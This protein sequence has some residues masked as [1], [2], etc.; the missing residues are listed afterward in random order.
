MTLLV[1][2]PALPVRD[3]PR[4]VAFYRDRLGFASRHVDDGMGIVVRD[5]VEI[6]L[7]RANSPTTPGAE[8]Y[9]AGSASCRIRVTNLRDLYS[10]YQEQKV[11]HPNGAL[12]SRPWGDDDFTILDADGNAIAFCERSASS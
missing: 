5:A 11:V 7:W 6:H 4:A 9:L 1:A 10:E 8:P 2:I 3:I 12:A